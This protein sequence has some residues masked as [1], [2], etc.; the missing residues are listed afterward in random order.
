MIIGLDF[1]NTIVNYD[2][3][4]HSI[5]R[6]RKLLIG[7]VQKSKTAVRDN[8]REHGRE[9]EWVVLQGLV[10]GSKM[11]RADVFDG[12]LSFL[13]WARKDKH[14]CKIISHKTEYPY[15]GPKVNLH[16]AARQWICKKLTVSSEMLIDSDDVFF[17]E[18]QCAYMPIY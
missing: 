10:Y 5:A 18:F 3:V 2:N 8:L 11:H 7:E 12:V 4:F 14:Q 15:A 13:T 17:N 1:D 16:E 6:E 9:D